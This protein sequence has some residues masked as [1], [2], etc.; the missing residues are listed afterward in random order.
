[1]HPRGG[2]CI[3]PPQWDISGRNQRIDALGKGRRTPTGDKTLRAMWTDATRQAQ[4]A[5]SPPDVQRPAALQARDALPP[6]NTLWSSDQRPTAQQWDLFPKGGRQAHVEVNRTQR[7]AIAP[8]VACHSY[9]HVTT[10]RPTSLPSS[11]LAA[12][13]RGCG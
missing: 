9:N 4:P 10:R 3:V 11:K 12:P 5:K 2:H 6:D 7:N 1:M 13:R 8:A